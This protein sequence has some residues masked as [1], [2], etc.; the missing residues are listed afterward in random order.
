MY[1]KPNN[2]GLASEPKAVARRLGRL[3]TSLA[4]EINEYTI[5]RGE[6]TEE[7]HALRM[8]IHETAQAEGWRIKATANGW[9]VLQPKGGAS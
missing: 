3:L 7:L 6:L 4:V 5:E 8:K 1:I 9:R 2:A